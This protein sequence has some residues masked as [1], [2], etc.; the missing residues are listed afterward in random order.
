MPSSSADRWVSGVTWAPSSSD[1]AG[2]H[3]VD[4]LRQRPVARVQE[5][6]LLLDPER[7]LAAGVPLG[8]VRQLAHAALLTLRGRRA[9]RPAP[10]TGLRAR[11]G[12]SASRRATGRRRRSRG[13]G[14]RRPRSG[15]RRPT[16]PAGARPK[17]SMAW[18]WKELT[19]ASVRAHQLARWL[20]AS[21]VTACV[22]SVP[23]SVWRWSSRCWCRVPPRATFSV[24]APRQMASTGRPSAS[25]WRAS[26]S[27]NRSTSGSIGPGVGVQL[28]AV[29]AGIQVRAAGQAD[30]RDLAQQRLDGVVVH[31]RD[32]QRDAARRL[33]RAGVAQAQRQLLARGL[34]VR[35]LLVALHATH[36]RGRDCDQRPHPITHVSLPPP[37]REL[38]TTI[39]P[40]R[41]AT[42]V[43]AAGRDGAVA[44]TD[45][46]R[47]QVHMTGFQPTV[48]DGRMG[49]QR[50]HLLG[51][52]RV[53]ALA[54]HPLGL[55]PA[56]RREHGRHSTT[57]SPP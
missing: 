31:R 18:W 34:A 24:W 25:A 43:R 56:P 22:A 27:S 54:H 57:P 46:E 33:H 49:G 21:I 29:E 45:H 1:R 12:G 5:H 42:R 35:G 6:D 3:A 48:D 20:P 10:R 23:G 37:S 40:A 19:C 2:Q 16:R 39:S 53:R 55:A 17:R 41:S 8:P 32:H 13:R 47:S 38:L 30:A 4:L 50:D 52:E 36:L 7:V 28:G 51:H 15:R 26:S 11:A 44:T 14:P 9:K